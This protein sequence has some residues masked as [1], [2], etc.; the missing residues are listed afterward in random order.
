MSE[1]TSQ[2]SEPSQEADVQENAEANESPDTGEVDYK[3]EA[4]KWKALARK[5][6]ANAKSNAEKAKK[7]D[8]LE[9]SQKTEQQK[10]SDE[11]DRLKSENS[12]LTASQTRLEVAL[13]KAPEGMS[14][15]QIR[16]LAKRL[17]GD[18]REDLEADAEELFGDFA[19]SNESGSKS[20]RPKERLRP[21]SAPEAEPEKSPAE[22]AESV[23]KKSR[24]F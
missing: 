9:E 4:E 5:H 22:L 14:V 15:P 16:K 3:A 8:E 12:T 2:T 13:D 21:G 18:S 10:V 1:E 7:A 17:T 23:I 6:E 24:G 20:R 19:P 11:L